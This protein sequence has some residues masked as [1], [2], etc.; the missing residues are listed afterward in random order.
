MTSRPIRLAG[1]VAA[2]LALVVAGA[3]LSRQGLAN[4]FYDRAADALADRP[5][6]AIREANSSLRLDAEEPP[7][8]PRQ[9]RGSGPLQPGRLRRRTTPRAASKEPELT[10]SDTAMLLGLPRN[11]A[12]ARRGGP[13]QLRASLPTLNPIATSPCASPAADPRSRLWRGP[14]HDDRYPLPR[15]FSDAPN[16]DEQRSVLLGVLAPSATAQPDPEPGVTIDPGSPIRE[17]VWDP[18]STCT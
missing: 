4:L 10:S 18:W 2:G 11:P 3:S 14:G 15:M 13:P 17:G 6:D 7:H 9:G 16:H 5:A 8:L 1:A 12:R